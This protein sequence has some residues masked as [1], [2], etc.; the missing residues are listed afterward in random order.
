MKKKEL[1]NL[2]NFEKIKNLK[3]TVKLTKIKFKYNNKL[4]NNKINHFLTIFSLYLFTTNSALAW[5]IYLSKFLIDSS[6]IFC[7]GIEKRSKIAKFSSIDYFGIF[8]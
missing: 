8:Y 3:K 2:K 5:G 7:I 6:S 4:Y 1:I